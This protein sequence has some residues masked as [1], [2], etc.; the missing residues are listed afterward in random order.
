M[1]SVHTYNVPSNTKYLEVALSG[2]FCVNKYTI[3]CLCTLSVTYSIRDL[4]TVKEYVICYHIVE[5]P[6]PAPCS[7][8]LMKI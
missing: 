4:N 1:K 6:K 2:E 7:V 8:L 5:I 3:C